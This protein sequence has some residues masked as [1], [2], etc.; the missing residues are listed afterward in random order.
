LRPEGLITDVRH[1]LRRFARRPGP[2]A[3]AALTL[4]LGCGAVTAAFSVLHGVVLKPLPYA[5]PDALV[6]V[7]GSQARLGEQLPASALDFLDWRQRA[8]SFQALAARRPASVS[9]AFGSELEQVAAE[10]VSAAYF[11]VLGVRPVLG[12]GFVAAEDRPGGAPV[13]VLRES[14]W[15][16]RFSGD[17]GLI[18]RPLAIDG[19][20]HTLIGVAPDDHR[21]SV[22]AWLPLGLDPAAETDRDL[23]AL[24]VLG[25]LG[26][27]VGLAAAQ[28]EM[29]GIAARIAREHPETNAGLRVT[30]T[31]LGEAVARG[32]RPALQ[33]LL[34]AAALVLLIACANAASLLL[35]RN[36]V[37]E[38]ELAIRR[39]LGAGRAR[40]AALLLVEGGLLGLL[41]AGVGLLIAAWGTHALLALRPEGLPRA[42]GVGIDAR[43][44]AVALAVSLGAGLLAS[45]LPALEAARVDPAPALREGGRAATAARRAGRMRGVLVVAE[46]ALAL[47]LCTGAGLL[48]RSHARLS[49]VDPGFEAHGVAV[50]QVRLPETRYP[51]GGSRAAFAREA[52]GAARKLPGVQ[53][54]AL[55]SNLP[56]S[57]VVRR[58]RFAVGGLPIPAVGAAPTAVTRSVS[59]GYF[60]TLRVPILEGRG[61]GE[62]DAAGAPAVVVVSQR[63]ARRLWPGGAVGRQLS[64]GVAA[65]A[66]PPE[67]ATVVGVAGDTRSSSLASEPPDEIYWPLA[68][69]PTA[70]LSFALRAS[71]PAAATAALARQLQAQDREL[72]VYGRAT[73]AQA[74]ANAAGAAR[75]SAWLL[76]AFA[77]AALLLAATG[78]YALI[79][80]L[81]AQRARDIDIRVALGASDHDVLWLVARRGLGLTAAGL[82]LGLLAASRLAGFL[83]ALL[84]ATTPG[85]AAAFGTSAALL[86][87]VALLAC[88]LPARRAARTRP[89]RVL[90]AD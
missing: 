27:G 41:G 39:A 90:R 65:P 60:E 55:A 69:R 32:V 53:A 2:T 62:R 21:G 51:D 23:R 16:E 7:T 25:R 1:T 26:D 28:A 43:V 66:E 56:F 37:R 64:W 10:R 9:L 54:A 70:S 38:R 82:A 85:D 6:L 46:L 50:A 61:L 42:A 45:L 72:P 22:A 47:A 63:L 80:D 15:R 14:Y 20:P 83:Q 29:D 17:G 24:T 89:A 81:V 40:V 57:G 34:A 86:A 18:G 4:G 71:E 88:W 30:L 13:V 77:G 52:L 12:R 76:S 5:Q 68:Q 75:F 44:L 84:F 33:R 87:S 78:V 49:G 8:A 59:P 35:A 3:L 67:W 74:V 19:V 73:L 11:D 58:Q 79:S 31:P 48:L 36:A